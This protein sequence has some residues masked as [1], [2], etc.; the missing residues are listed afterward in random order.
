MIKKALQKIMDN[1]DG[2]LGVTLIGVDGLPIAEI[3]PE[4]GVEISVLGAELTILYKNAARLTQDL[5]YGIFQEITIRSEKIAII[6]RAVTV[7]YFLLLAITPK[8]LF[9]KG[10]YQLRKSVSVFLEQL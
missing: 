3:K 4:S 7:E 2:A 6:C 8:A 9:G 1:V 5:D 10:R